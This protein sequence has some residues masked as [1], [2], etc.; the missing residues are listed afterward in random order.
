MS[1]FLFVIVATSTL[2]GTLKEERVPWPSADAVARATREVTELY[3]NR[4]A[5]AT[6]SCDQVMLGRELLNIAGETADDP[7][8]Q[9]VLY[10]TARDLGAKAKD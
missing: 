3:G 6:K 8:V 5:R 9:F 4:L 2:F 10:Y 7:A 1:T